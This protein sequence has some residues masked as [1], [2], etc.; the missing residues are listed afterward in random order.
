MIR[1]EHVLVGIKEYMLLLVN[2]GVES[3]M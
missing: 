3:D 2:F 1:L